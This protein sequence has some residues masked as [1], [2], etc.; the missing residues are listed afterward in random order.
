VLGPHPYPVVVRDFQSVIG[1]EVLSQIKQAEGSLPDYLIACVGG[2]SN[3]IGLFYPFL[4]FDE[5]EMIGVEAGG[6]GISSGKHAARFAKGRE[7]IIE[8]YRSLF[9]QNKDGQSLETHSV[10]AGLDYIG[11]GPE[12]AYLHSTGRVKYTSATDKETINA[13][14][15]LVKT[16]GIIPAL[17]S[18]HA[19]AECIKLA[20]KLHMDKIIIVNISGRGDK[21][22]F[23]VA[24]ALKD[25]E[26]VEFLKTK[27]QEAG[28]A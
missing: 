13:L 25:K 3:S 11:V 17:E 7:G 2:G 12:H 28:Q 5:V 8:G 4:G 26:W 22:I 6:L 20:S 19:I 15:L 10:A 23:L 1:R 24:E 27:V 14:K 9:L 18:S 21:D 16:E